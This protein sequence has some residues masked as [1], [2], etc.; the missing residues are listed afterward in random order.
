MQSDHSI[1]TISSLPRVNTGNLDINQR[2]RLIMFQKIYKAASKTSSLK[3]AEQTTTKYFN[4]LEYYIKRV[5][6]NSDCRQK[7]MNFFQCIAQCIFPKNNITPYLFDNNIFYYSNQFQ[8][9]IFTKNDLENLLTYCP[10][11]SD[12]QQEQ[13]LKDQTWPHDPQKAVISG[14]SLFQ[15]L[16]PTLLELSGIFYWY[17]RNSYNKTSLNQAPPNISPPF[18]FVRLIAATYLL[19]KLS[20]ELLSKIIAQNDTSDGQNSAIVKI[21][22]EVYRQLQLSSSLFS[23]FHVRNIIAPPIENHISSTSNAYDNIST[24]LYTISNGNIKTISKFFHLIAISY[25]G[26]NFRMTSTLS[27]HKLTVIHCT[28]K[29]FIKSLLR[30]IFASSFT[31]LEL[32]AMA[33]GLNTNINAA[34]SLLHPI[35]Y[36]YTLSEL[37]DFKSA[38]SRISD[39][40]IATT[41]NIDDTPLTGREDLSLFKKLIS[42]K[43]FKI[44]DDPIFGTITH[45]SITHYIYIT[46]DLAKTRKV[47]ADLPEDSSYDLIDF[48]GDISQNSFSYLFPFEALF[49]VLTSI[50]CFMDEQ[51][52]DSDKAS[53][54][55]NMISAS[56]HPL[57]QEESLATF[58]EKFCTNTTSNIP[59]EKIKTIIDNQTIEGSKNDT[60]RKNLATKLSIDKLNYTT[61]DDLIQAYTAWHNTDKTNIC[62]LSK[63]LTDL[64]SKKISPVFYVKRD[65][66]VSIYDLKENTRNVKVFYGITLNKYKLNAY[67]QNSQHE[68][69]TV[70][71]SIVKTQFKNY[72][73]QLIKDFTTKTNQIEQLF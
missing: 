55:Q 42:S 36:Q 37:S 19:H 22:E 3:T 58:L 50:Y 68:Q 38:T 17:Q 65:K 52:D 9:F 43:R 31:D 4:N 70:D 14:L 57:T 73:Q 15:V 8:S 56:D 10:Y 35:C 63:N 23:Y 61:K 26:T 11:L 39:D 45:D 13:F 25:L 44:L 32:E 41:I 49:I 6:P 24:I 46:D 34:K 66:A 60:L 48:K 2:S 21:T 29:L 53:H 67:I 28:N 1:I 5:C 72:F 16:P 27:H 59:E 33:Y 69:K 62:D 47:L 54:H 64:L 12:K 30:S 20:P 71:A 40:F 7:S 51:S 18:T